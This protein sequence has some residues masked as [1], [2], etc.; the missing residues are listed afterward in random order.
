[1]TEQAITLVESAGQTARLAPLP[2]PIAVAGARGG[3]VHAPSATV[4]T[5]KDGTQR[6]GG[7]ARN[8]PHADADAGAAMMQRCIGSGARQ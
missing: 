4:G 6:I 8:R 1:M 3:I 2:A 7:G 5:I